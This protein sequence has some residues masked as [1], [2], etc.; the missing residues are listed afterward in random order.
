MKSDTEE[1]PHLTEINESTSADI[2]T[3][4]LNESYL[5]EFLSTE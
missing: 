5:D 3:V 2:G 4:S 1:T